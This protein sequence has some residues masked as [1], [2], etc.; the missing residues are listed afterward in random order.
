MGGD[1]GYH[2]TGAARVLA[3]CEASASGR[4]VLERA[5]SMAR[6]GGAELTVLAL[7]RQD[8]A[9]PHCTV[10]GEAYNQAVRADAQA[11]LE[12]AR[13]AIGDLPLARFE[14]LIEGR[15]PPLARWAQGRFDV[16]LLP[17]RRF[18]R[19]GT[20]PW[21]AELAGAGIARVLVIG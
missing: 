11:E 19:R 15:D 7:A 16:A 10:Y 4:A 17:S 20:H 2:R 6:E 12:H 18:L 1:G 8:T 13:G 9:P 14:L 3:V 5:A 21:Q